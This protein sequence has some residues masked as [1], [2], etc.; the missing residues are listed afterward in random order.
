MTGIVF[1][2]SMIF[3]YAFSTLPLPR[4]YNFW[5]PNNLLN[6][7]DPRIGK[8]RKIIGAT[9]SVSAQANIGAHFSQREEI[10]ALRC[11]KWVEGI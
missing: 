1:L 7:Q 9:A 4:T 8:I 10:L 2:A 5:Q 3:G 6:R 11:F